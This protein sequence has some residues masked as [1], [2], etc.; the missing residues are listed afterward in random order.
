MASAPSSSSPAPLPKTMKAWVVTRNGAPRDA[1]ALKTEWP[2]PPAPTGSDVLLRVLAAALNPADTHFIAH[3]PSWLPFRRNATP[4]LDFAGGVVAVGPA[5]PADS[6]AARVGAV[7]C[8]SLAVGLV[9]AG[10]GAL[11]EYLVVPADLVAAKPEGLDPG[12]A[13]GL[14]GVAGQTARLV[15]RS[16][17]GG[18]V[19][20]GDR[21]LINGASGG[22]GSLL[23]QI[24]KAKGAVVVAVCSDANA[25]MVKQLGADGVRIVFL[26]GVHLNQADKFSFAHFMML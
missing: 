23:V 5:V 24:A 10:R 22:V 9:A 8:G 26:R 25:A 6:P 7:V 13:A 3:I 16:A 19:R 20:E 17:P 4:G 12:R 2:A 1:L 21:V 11:A 14:L 18:D 15:V